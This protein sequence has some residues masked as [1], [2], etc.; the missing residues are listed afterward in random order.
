M[1][2]SNQCKTFYAATDLLVIATK[3]NAFHV[4]FNKLI[5]TFIFTFS[6]YVCTRRKPRRKK[7][8]STA[9]FMKLI[10]STYCQKRQKM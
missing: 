7:T 1:T 5:N 4:W 9:Q 8:E 2:S 3:K 10:T 6:I